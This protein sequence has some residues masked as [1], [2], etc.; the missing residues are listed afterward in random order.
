MR[1]GRGSHLAS[2]SG[3]VQVKREYL[4]I[5]AELS[6]PALRVWCWL[7]KTAT[8]RNEIHDSMETIMASAGVCERDL[9]R[10]YRE[11]EERKMIQRES[12]KIHLNAA[13]VWRSHLEAIGTA[14]LYCEPQTNGRR[15][16]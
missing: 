11:L 5:W 8:P 2:G 9:Y 1:K 14:R 7:L 6:R 12:G 15:A 10:A 16:A 4:H 13:L 3:F